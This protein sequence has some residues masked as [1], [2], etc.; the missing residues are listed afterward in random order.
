MSS[1]GRCLCIN[2]VNLCAGLG[3]CA[4]WAPLLAVVTLSCAAGPDR[5]QCGRAAHTAT[6]RAQLR[7]V[8]L[9]RP[10][11]GPSCAEA[12]CTTPAKALTGVSGAQLR[13]VRATTA[14]YRAPMLRCADAPV[15][16]R[17]PHIVTFLKAFQYTLRSGLIVP[18]LECVSCCFVVDG[19]RTSRPRQY[20]S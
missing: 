4:W 9:A 11:V 1:C 2:P 20:N 17:A 15:G 13:G 7:S 10:P 3:L 19:Q 16:A 14:T 5:W 8:G 6:S 18:V 12:G